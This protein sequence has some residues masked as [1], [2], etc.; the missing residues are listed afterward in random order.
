[1]DGVSV[2]RGRRELIE[3]VQ[4]P[5]SRIFAFDPMYGFAS[6]DTT[7]PAVINSL[8]TVTSGA[9]VW[10]FSDDATWEQ[11]ANLRQDVLNVVP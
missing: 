8:E 1:M 11:V 4:A 2:D 10:I 7:L 3:T 9:G 6:F 5:V